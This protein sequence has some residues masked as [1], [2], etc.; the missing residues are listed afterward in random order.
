[1]GGLPEDVRGRLEKEME[2]FYRWPERLLYGACFIAAFMLLMLVAIFSLMLFSL[3][4]FPVL[5]L[6]VKFHR[7]LEASLRHSV[8]SDALFCVLKFGPSAPELNSLK[9]ILNLG[10]IKCPRYE[11]EKTLALLEAVREARKFE[12]LRASYFLKEFEKWLARD[13]D[14]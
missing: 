9:Q 13:L 1:M 10:E 12:R 4:A 2:A 6:Q 7:A 3:A 11:R 5:W 14:S 8:E